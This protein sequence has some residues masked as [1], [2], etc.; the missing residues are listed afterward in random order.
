MA[1][2]QKI[3]QVENEHTKGKPLYGPILFKRLHKQPKT[4]E[5]YMIVIEY[6]FP[7]KMKKKK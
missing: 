3:V 4:T 6:Y 2:F 7:Q 1:F 5:T